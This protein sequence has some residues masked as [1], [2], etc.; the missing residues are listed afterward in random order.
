MSPLRLMSGSAW[1][2]DVR[3]YEKLDNPIFALRTLKKIGDSDFLKLL[4]ETVNENLEKRGDF[5]KI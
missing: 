5:P 2:G 3:K 1:I 4:L